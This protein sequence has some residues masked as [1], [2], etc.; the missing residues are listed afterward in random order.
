M[1]YPQ[2]LFGG[3]IV[4]GSIFP[5]S[6]NATQAG[7]NL[8]V[9][10]TPGKRIVVLKYKYICARAGPVLATWQSSGGTILD[11][12]CDIAATGGAQEPFTVCGHFS[13]LPGEDLVLFLDSAIQVGGNLLYTLL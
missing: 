4:N 5:A 13:T 10:T 1:A 7:V 2:N 12:P 3:T 8:V 9:P 11:G 6:I